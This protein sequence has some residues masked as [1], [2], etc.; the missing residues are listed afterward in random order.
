MT[1]SSKNSLFILFWAVT[2]F[3]SAQV[4]LNVHQHKAES[5]F[6]IPHFDYFLQTDTIVYK[7]RGIKSIQASINLAS[8]I[9]FQLKNKTFFLDKT[10]SLSIVI[11]SLNNMTFTSKYAGNYIFY[12]SLKAIYKLPVL[13]ATQSLNLLSSLKQKTFH[14]NLQLLENFQRK[15]RTSADF[16]EYIKSEVYFLHYLNVYTPIFNKKLQ[17]TSIPNDYLSEINQLYIFTNKAFNSRAYQDFMQRFIEF[18]ADTSGTETGLRKL[19]SIINFIDSKFDKPHQEWLKTGFLKSYSKRIKPRE[20]V[21]FYAL[22]DKVE[23]DLSN[24]AYKRLCK[25]IMT[26]IN[27]RPVSIPDEVLNYKLLTTNNHEI[28]LQQ[29]LDANK[30]KI[31]YVDFWATWCGPCIEMLPYSKKLKSTPTGK[32]IEIVYISLD[33][34]TDAWQKGLKKYELL[35]EQNF[36]LNKVGEPSLIEK[37]FNVDSIPRYLILDKE[38]KLVNASAPRPDRVSLLE[39]II[40]LLNKN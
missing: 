21:A 6:Y 22:V 2:N 37:Y 5:T 23:A 1:T 18:Y 15:H 40:N 34:T 32:D 16:D 17:G 14:D 26:F 4:S 27:R 30:G 28:S 7:S 35:A 13:R 24:E 11:D 29:I 20:T 8:S 36:L 10:D 19:T 39:S 3:C 12:D 25:K 33:Y 38:G 9:P 31:I